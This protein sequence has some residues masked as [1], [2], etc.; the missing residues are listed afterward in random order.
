MIDN[1]INVGKAPFANRVGPSSPFTISISLSH[2]P[3][4]LSLSLL[5]SLHSLSVCCLSSNLGVA[6]ESF[7]LMGSSP[8]DFVS[9]YMIMNGTSHD[10]D[11]DGND[12]DND[13]GNHDDDQG[14][15]QQQQQQHAGQKTMGRDCGVVKNLRAF[16]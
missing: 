12:D 14:K 15:Q 6:L 5:H 16:R 8:N 4:S 9:I 11:D 10:D 2:N 7:W 3:P 1:K 13:D